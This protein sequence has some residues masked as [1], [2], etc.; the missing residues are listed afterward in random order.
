MIYREEIDAGGPMPPTKELKAEWI[1]AFE[2][3]ILAGMPET[4]EDLPVTPITP[5]EP[6]VEATLGTEPTP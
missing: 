1:D 6:T 2:R 5:P 3:W 4:V